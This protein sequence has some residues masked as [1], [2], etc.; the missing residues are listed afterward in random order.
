MYNSNESEIITFSKATPLGFRV[1][2]NLTPERNRY[3]KFSNF[4]NPR[5]TSLFK[6]QCTIYRV[7]TLACRNLY[8]WSLVIRVGNEISLSLSA[9]ILSFKETRGGAKS[10]HGIF[11]D[12]MNKAKHMVYLITHASND[13]LNSKTNHKNNVL[14][15]WNKI[16]QI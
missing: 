5:L 3:M 6:S 1:C 16:I 15:L 12:W 9:R 4:P 11:T 8:M 14:C 7:K 2:V 13:I 10:S